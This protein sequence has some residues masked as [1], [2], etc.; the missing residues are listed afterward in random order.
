MT[1]WPTRRIAD[2][3]AGR[4]MDASMAHD[5]D[6]ARR[7]WICDALA[8]HEGALLRFALR[9]CG[10]ADR[11]RD[12]VQETFLRLC[13]EPIEAVRGHEAAWLFRVCRQR[14]LDCLRKEQ[15]MAVADDAVSLTADEHG[16]DDAAELRDESSRLRA[17]M[18]ELPH[19][20]Q[21]LLRL[22]FRDGLSY[23]QIAEALEMSVTNVGFQLHTTLAKLRSRMLAHE[24]NGHADRPH[25]SSTSHAGRNR[26]S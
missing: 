1:A 24:T 18:G 8:R 3:A 26:I 7:V 20:Q 11:A 19:R 15:R 5:S 6:E 17:L 23:R 21:D 25:N 4:I 9:L 2:A 10:D 13:R 22:K 12:I 14:A 16:P